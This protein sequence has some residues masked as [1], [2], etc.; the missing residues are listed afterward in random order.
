MTM[1]EMVSLARPGLEKLT[2]V[3]R[4]LVDLWSVDRLMPT[5]ERCTRSAEEPDLEHEMKEILDEAW[6]LPRNP[7]TE[8]RAQHLIKRLEG[9]PHRIEHRCG[10]FF[11]TAQQLVLQ[12]DA[13]IEAFLQGTVDA[14]EAALVAALETQHMKGEE[15]VMYDE[16]AP[17]VYRLRGEGIRPST[18]A[19][20]EEEMKWRDE[21]TRVASGFHDADFAGMRR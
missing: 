16:G 3:Q 15:S 8:V 12:L 18:L 2:A 6:D 14:A 9:L 5:Y 11:A 19:L 21:N 10:E 7:L 13:A 17:S 4:Y 1:E 20:M